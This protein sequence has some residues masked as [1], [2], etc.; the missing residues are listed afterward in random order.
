MEDGI[1]EFIAVRVSSTI[2]ERSLD[3]PAALSD[4]P[5]SNKMAAPGPLT[6]FTYTYG[7]EINAL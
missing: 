7:S 6:R 2:S 1:S 5:L 4:S 3:N